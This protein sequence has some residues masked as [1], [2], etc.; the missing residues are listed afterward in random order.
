M[1][2]A[3]AVMF[4]GVIT[5]TEPIASITAL[6]ARTNPFARTLRVRTMRPPLRLL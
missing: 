5:A 2:D 6:D 3:G 4:V 1:A